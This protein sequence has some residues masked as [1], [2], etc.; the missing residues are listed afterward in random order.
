MMI[1]QDFFYN[2]IESQRVV[3]YK[4]YLS[5]KVAINTNI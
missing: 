3:L 5:Q 4:K 2:T 1:L